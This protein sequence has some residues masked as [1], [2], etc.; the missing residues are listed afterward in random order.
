MINQVRIRLHKLPKCSTISYTSK[1]YGHLSGDAG[2]HDRQ[3]KL[4]QQK[5]GYKVWKK[6]LKEFPSNNLKT[7]LKRWIPAWMTICI[8]WI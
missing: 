1:N 4:Q 5:M 8:L 6:N 3:R 7:L 2:H